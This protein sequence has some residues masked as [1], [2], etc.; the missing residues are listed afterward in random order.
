[1]H[2]RSTR[3][4]DNRCLQG[5]GRPGTSISSICAQ[6][7]AFCAMLAFAPLGSAADK[8]A[9]YFSGARPPYLVPVG[10]SSMAGLIGTPTT[11][12][13]EAANVTFEWGD[14]PASRLIAELKSDRKPACAPGYFQTPERLTWAKFSKPIYRDSPQA[15]LANTDF[16]PS[17]DKLSELLMRRDIALLV[18]QD[19]SYGAGIDT[20]L[21]QY[22][23]PMVA[24]TADN[25]RMVQMINAGRADFMFITE[26]EFSALV[27]QTGV[28]NVRLIHMKDSPVGEFRYIM[29][30]SLVSDDTMKK[31]DDA[32]SAY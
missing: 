15:L 7:F 5:R 19:F 25:A 27:A 26:E 17:T 9:L 28:R 16:T 8:V 24:V 30:N 14:L 20:M 3:S 12:A 23:P 2:P 6:A 11:K 32:I 22:K 13:F 21:A 18:R 31:I 10:Q 4:K 29:C 1:M